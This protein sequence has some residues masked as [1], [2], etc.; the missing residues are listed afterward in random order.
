MGVEKCDAVLLVKQRK[1]KITTVVQ[2][3]NCHKINIRRYDAKVLRIN[4]LW[5]W[6]NN[7][8]KRKENTNKLTNDT[9]L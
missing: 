5:Q 7:S 2:V 6:Q 9:L 3:E 8:R 4:E 1:K